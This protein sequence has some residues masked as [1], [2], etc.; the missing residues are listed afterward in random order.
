M[1][2]PSKVS[3]KAA[4]EK[5]LGVPWAEWQTKKRQEWRQVISAL[6]HFEFGAAYTP[7][8]TDLYMLR[9][10]ADRIDGALQDDWVSW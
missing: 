2:K 7:G 10:M 8:G 4:T 9:Q 6:K 3:R 5:H 1:K